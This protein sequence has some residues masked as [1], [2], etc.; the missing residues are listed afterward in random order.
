MECTSC[1]GPVKR[2]DRPHTFFAHDMDACPSCAAKI[3]ARVVF[4]D[5]KTVHLMH[6]T[7]CGPQEKTL[8]VSA[9]AYVKQFLQRGV[10]PDGLVGDHLF[11]HTT[12]TCP[13]CLALVTAE[14][15]IRRDQVFFLKDCERC[16][17]SEALVSE[18]ASYYVK[19]YAFARAGTQ[20]LQFRNTAEHGC[21]TDCGTCDDHEQ[22]TCL[23]IVEVTDHCNLECPI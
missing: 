17:P 15:V 21:P 20:P 23:P 3:E 19:A 5:G 8:A 18:D 10:V 14:V 6:C 12:S 11:K 16:G 13:R 22:H 9:E 7:A 1:D 4:R 2:A